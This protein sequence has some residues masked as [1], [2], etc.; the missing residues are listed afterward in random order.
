VGDGFD[1][2]DE[3]SHA[4]AVSIHRSQ[5]SGTRTC[6]SPGGGR[7]ADAAAQPA[8]RRRAQG[9]VDRGAGR[10]Q[11]RAGQSGPHPGRRARPYRPG[12]AAAVGRVGAVTAAG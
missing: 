10:Q 2:L 12:R 6:S 5:G 11:T 3:L 8:L 9:Q 1:E 4:Y 7:L